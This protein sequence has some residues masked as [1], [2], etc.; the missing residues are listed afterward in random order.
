MR[1]LILSNNI[2]GLYSFRKELVQVLIN[3][4]YEV[5]ISCPIEDNII[6][7]EWFNK[8]GCEII[9]T[10]FNRK[11]TNPIA[12]FRLLVRYIKM[13][14]R[15][16]PKVVLSYTIKPNVYGGLAGAFCGVPQV[17]NITGLGAAVENPGLLQKVAIFM[18]KIGM[19]KTNMTFFQNNENRQ[20]CLSHGMV[21]GL[22]QLI[23]GSGVNLDYHKMEPYP[24][25]AESIRFLFVSRIRKEK[26]IEEYL[27]CAEYIRSKYPYV[28]FHIVGF[29]EGDYEQRLTDMQRK[30]IIVFHGKQSDVRPFYKMA[31]CTIHP[32]FYPEGMS[33]VLLESC[34][35]GRPI[36]T[37]DRAGCREIVEDGVNGYV[38]RQRD[39]QDL[40][41]KV[42]KFI[43][44]PYEEKVAMGRAARA[45]MEREFDRK[46]VVDAYLNAIKNLK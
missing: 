2:I 18:C 33:N 36:I 40:I 43:S 27:S 7:T 6:Q 35:T 38:V 41:K 34:A 4:G 23:P 13:L 21:R 15:L 31:N 25:V 45:K 5:F 16:S 44:L 22:N 12:D 19:R 3:K 39:A 28:E 20:F 29:C 26:G 9:D 32:T 30:S 1:I 11:G 17:A 46:I 24:N 10:P 14:K 42:E 8:L 37:T